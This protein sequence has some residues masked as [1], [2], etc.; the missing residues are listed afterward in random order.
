MKYLKQVNNIRVHI[1]S[2]GE[3][4]CRFKDGTVLEEFRTIEQ[5]I[6]WA[7]KTEDFLRRTR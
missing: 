2:R 7:T 3:G 4:Q 1:G 5:A 6:V